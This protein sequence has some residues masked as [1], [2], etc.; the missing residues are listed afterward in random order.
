M[1][2]EKRCPECGINILIDEFYIRRDR[3]EG[4][5]CSY[6]KECAKKRH[7]KRYN[8]DPDKHRKASREWRLANRFKVSLNMSRQQARKNGYLSCNATEGKL[9]AAFTGKCEICGV[10]E[11]EC[12]KNLCLDHCHETGEFRGWLCNNCNAAIGMLKD[13]REIALNALLYIQ[14]HDTKIPT[15]KE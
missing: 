8:A 7:R 5:P 15:E 4:R 3:V 13:S 6:C 1:E 11:Q 9:R 12:D 10:P 14:R 2:E